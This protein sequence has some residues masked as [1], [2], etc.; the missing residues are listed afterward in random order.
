MSAAVQQQCV[1]VHAPLLLA[2]LLLQTCACTIAH[3]QD[4]KY[5]IEI[6]NQ[7]FDADR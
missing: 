1:A 6:S 4:D 5:N 2:L 7:E 3:N